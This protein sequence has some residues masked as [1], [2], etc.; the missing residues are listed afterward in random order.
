MGTIQQRFEIDHPSSAVYDEISRPQN[1][2]EHLPGVLA[3]N[4]IADDAYKLTLTAAEGARELD[5]HITR[6]PELRRIEWRT[7]EPAWSGAVT[8]EAIGPARTAVGVHAESTSEGLA[9]S[10]ST[11]HDILQA[12]KHALQAQQ[13]RV[14][15]GEDE[16]LAGRQAR[17][18]RRYASDWR[19]AARSA[20]THPTHYP[21]TLARTLAEQMER[22]WE[23]MWR[24]TPVARLPHFMPALGSHP[25]V[26]VC[27]RHDQVRICVDV[28][29]VDES[30]LSVEIQDGCLTIRGERQDDRGDDGGRRR[31]EF[32]YGSF[33]RR[34][35]L[36]EGVNGDAA[37]AILRN[38]VLEIRIP[39]ERRE[40][41][42][43][44][45]QHAS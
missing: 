40:P 42:R 30:Q 34:V 29:G 8:L 16:T 43:V 6:S 22:V 35:P 37:K 12:F 11:V 20:F 27:E 33:T 28:P 32:N 7:L 39:I 18:S 31:S 41:R 44:P 24:G 14:S 2:L 15:R 36:P 3:V 38:G 4:R 5:L 10:P 19:E 25:K 23:Q 21:F 1:V 26:E 45:V 9:P 13:V 17:S